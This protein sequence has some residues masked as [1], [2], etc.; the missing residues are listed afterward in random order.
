MYA[1]NKIFLV[2]TAALYKFELLDYQ[3]YLQ[4]PLCLR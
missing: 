1:Q 3:D 4:S 2:H